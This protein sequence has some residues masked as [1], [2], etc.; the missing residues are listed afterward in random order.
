[1][2]LEA[3][4][5]KTSIRDAKCVPTI[6]SLGSR[7]AISTNIVVFVKMVSRNFF[8]IKKQ[9]FYFFVCVYYFKFTI[10]FDNFLGL[11]EHCTQQHK[12][13]HIDYYGEC[14]DN[15][16]CEPDVLIDFPRRMREWLYHILT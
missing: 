12:H 9:P 1:M 8:Q 5:P 11:S 15:I 14:T 6:T 2:N 3:N 13:M 7:I 16:K 4:V 10:I